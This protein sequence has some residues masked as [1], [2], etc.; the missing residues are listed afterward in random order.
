MYGC[1]MSISSS[2]VC[3]WPSPNARRGIGDDSA[4]YHLQVVQACYM[5]RDATGPRHA[6]LL[7]HFLRPSL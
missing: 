2:Q 5:I 3:C 6:G 4:G 1:R 7:K